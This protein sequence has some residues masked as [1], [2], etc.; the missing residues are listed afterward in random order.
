MQQYQQQL[1]PSNGFGQQS[2]FI[3]TSY[4][5][6]TI[7]ENSGFIQS[8]PTVHNLSSTSIKISV[9]FATNIVQVEVEKASQLCDLI[10]FLKEIFALE[11][12]LNHKQQNGNQVMNRSRNSL[13]T[14]DNPQIAL[15]EVRGPRTS[16]SNDDSFV[17]TVQ[18]L[19]NGGHYYMWILGGALRHTHK[20]L[21][22]KEDSAP[23]EA[24]N[25]KGT[26][27]EQSLF[28]SSTNPR[29]S[30]I[31]YTKQPISHSSVWGTSAATSSNPLQQTSR[32]AADELFSLPMLCPFLECQK[33]FRHSGNLKT[34]MRSHTNDRP[35]KC[36]HP[37]C[38]YSFITK[39]HLKTHLMN[40][41]DIKPHRCHLCSTSYSQKSRLQIHLRKHL[42]VKPFKCDICQKVFTEKGNL[43]VHLKSHHA[44]THSKS[45]SNTQMPVHQQQVSFGIPQ[46]SQLPSIPSFGST[47]VALERISGSNNSSVQQNHMPQA[48]QQDNQ[49]LPLVEQTAITS[50][51]S[52]KSFG[53]ACQIR[54]FEVNGAPIIKAL[55]TQQLIN[56]NA[57]LLIQPSTMNQQSAVHYSIISPPSQD[58]L[59]TLTLGNVFQKSSHAFSGQGNLSSDLHKIQ[60]QK[61]MMLSTTQQNDNDANSPISGL[62]QMN[63]RKNSTASNSSDF[64]AQFNNAPQVSGFRSLGTCPSQQYIEQ[65][66]FGTQPQ[67]INSSNGG[68]VKYPLSNGSSLDN[69]TPKSNNGFQQ[70]FHFTNPQTCNSQSLFRPATFAGLLPIQQKPLPQTNIFPMGQVTSYNSLFSNNLQQNVQQT[71]PAGSTFTPAGAFSTQSSF[72][73]ANNLGEAQINN[74]SMKFRI[75]SNGESTNITNEQFSAGTF[76]KEQS[77]VTTLFLSKDFQKSLLPAP[78]T[79]F[80]SINPNMHQYSQDQRLNNLASQPIFSQVNGGNGTSS[81]FF[82]INSQQVSRV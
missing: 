55:P 10:N 78:Q 22:P 14:T 40:H 16:A 67:F 1:Y 28:S 82:N 3:S 42:G 8:M 63:V 69:F 25:F 54:S 32:G 5:S 39:G 60:A 46:M 57:N 50:G 77:P 72:N 12:T 24:A 27:G 44:S 45:A 17:Q 79:Q 49:N 19:T 26:Y 58:T 81:Y 33:E 47:N 73:Q 61:M 68:Y 71:T 15:E 59:Q 13:K 38:H 66:S 30:N 23:F 4:P 21:L 43:K 20:S 65:N 7:I 37:G 80:G 9:I 75:Q 11:D 35:Y 70:A 34:H 51:N 18:Q 52:A 53:A 36:M 48:I 74:S 64:I 2:A 76:S 29:L 6:T 56:N 31:K 41:R 62:N